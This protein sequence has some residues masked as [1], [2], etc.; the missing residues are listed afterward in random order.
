MKHWTLETDAEKLMPKP[1]DG[2]GN[3]SL[4]MGTGKCTVSG[5]GC[6][7]YV[8]PPGGFDCAR[9]GHARSEHW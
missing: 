7:S 3:D 6:P 9:C 4:I 8:D 2:T 5:C 1:T